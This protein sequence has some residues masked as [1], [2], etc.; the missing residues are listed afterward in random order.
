MAM[1]VSSRHRHVRRGFARGAP[2]RFSEKK[3]ARPSV[4]T[5]HLGPFSDSRWSEVSRARPHPPPLCRFNSCSSVT[6]LSTSVRSAP[7]AA[8]YVLRCVGRPAPRS[9]RG[10]SAAPHPSQSLKER[11][12]RAF[13]LLVPN[14]SCLRSRSEYPA[15]RVTH[16][17]A[18]SR[19]W[20]WP[21][22]MTPRCAAFTTPGKER[23]S[24]RALERRANG[25]IA[26]QSL[27]QRRLSA[28][29]FS[30]TT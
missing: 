13:V 7:L 28:C 23:A 25:R 24:S 16:G 21:D 29:A 5:T 18:M 6:T 22:A 19:P 15:F 3:G 2:C 12:D 26:K 30:A 27:K 17:Q 8:S 10:A 1:P 4:V 9:T 11:R 14:P 20:P